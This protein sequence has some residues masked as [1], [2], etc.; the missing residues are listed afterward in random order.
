MPPENNECGA[1]PERRTGAKSVNQT[2]T[3]H[4]GDPMPA[5]AGP[6]WAS[7]QDGGL[8]AVV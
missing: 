4:R 3:T 7:C 5:R 1:P 2:R 6:L 8:S